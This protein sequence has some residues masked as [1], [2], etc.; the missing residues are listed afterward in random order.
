M[1]LH[2]IAMPESGPSAAGSTRE[3]GAADPAL[4]AP[5][6]CD[7][8]KVLNTH[9]TSGWYK[10]SAVWPVLSDIWR[11]ISE[12]L[13]DMHDAWNIAFDAECERARRAERSAS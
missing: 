5:L 8:N 2:G 10:Q 12:V 1:H 13:D 7:E 4:F 9:L 6:T 3:F 11:E